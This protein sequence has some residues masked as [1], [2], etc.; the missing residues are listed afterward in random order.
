MRRTALHP[1]A[2]VAIVEGKAKALAFLYRQ[3]IQVPILRAGA[4][5]GLRLRCSVRKEQVVGNILVARRA[6]L[7]QIIVPPQQIQ[8]RTNQVLLGDGFV[9]IT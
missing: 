1:V 4:G 9:G 5:A 2:P 6:L 7:R 8:H 3:R